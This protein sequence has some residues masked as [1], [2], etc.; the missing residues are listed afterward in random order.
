V[1]GDVCMQRCS[2]ILL[3]L[4]KAQAEQDALIRSMEIKGA[5]PSSAS[6]MHHHQ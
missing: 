1:D 6:S 2:Q 4:D 3:E 5:P